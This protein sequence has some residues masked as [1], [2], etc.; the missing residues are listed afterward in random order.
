VVRTVVLVEGLSDQLA[1][2]TLAGR[3]DRN[4]DAEGVAVVPMGGATNIGKFL[5]RY[6]P[7]G[8]DLRLAG[9]CDAAEEGAFRRGLERA[10][11]G[12]RLTRAGMEALG[13][14]VCVADLEDELIRAIGPATVEDVL[15]EHGDLD[16]FRTFQQQPAQ[17][18]R[19]VQ[20]QLRRF[21]GTRSGRKFDY[22]RWLVASLDLARVP[23]PLDGVL[24]HV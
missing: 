11:L 3:L 2:E 24:A 22:A 19:D 20:A 6:G 12:A 14:H 10:G 16:S 9:L 13:F 8:L 18:G 7:A 23:P 5:A 4:L 1:L 17:R 15:D 21:M